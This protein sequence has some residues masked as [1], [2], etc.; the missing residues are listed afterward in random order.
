LSQKRG[1]PARSPGHQESRAPNGPPTSAAQQPSVSGSVEPPA[2][3]GTDIHGLVILSG[4]GVIGLGMVL[5][6]AGILAPPLF[7]PGTYAIGIGMLLAAAGGGL[8]AATPPRPVP[9]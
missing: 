9:S 2:P 3:A 7:R 5:V 6:I 1:R 8:R 4:I